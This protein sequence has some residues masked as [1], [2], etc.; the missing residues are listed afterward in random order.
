MW[1]GALYWR[2]SRGRQVSQMPGPCTGNARNIVME[3][4]IEYVLSL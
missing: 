3:S 4:E 2:Q 1:V